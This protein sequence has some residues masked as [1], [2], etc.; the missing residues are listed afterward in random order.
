MNGKILPESKKKWAV[1]VALL[2]DKSRLW[3][4]LSFQWLVDAPYRQPAIGQHRCRSRRRSNHHKHWWDVGRDLSGNCGLV[5]K[6]QCVSAGVNNKIL[7]TPLLEQNFKIWFFI[8]L[9]RE[10]TRML[11]R[12]LQMVSGTHRHSLSWMWFVA[13]RAWHWMMALCKTD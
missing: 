8:V 3:P 1:T 9:A 13:R 11:R 10:R 12:I 6:Q 4:H 5:Q 2:T 7:N